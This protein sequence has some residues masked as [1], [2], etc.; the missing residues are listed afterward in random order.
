LE[1]ADWEEV[2]SLAPSVAHSAAAVVSGTCYL[3]VGCWVHSVVVEESVV[4]ASVENC[5]ELEKSSFEFD[6]SCQELVKSLL[7]LVE[8]LLAFRESFQAFG[9]DC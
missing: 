9:E 6:E 2:D 8:S 1:E 3:H 7:A 5:Q 4:F